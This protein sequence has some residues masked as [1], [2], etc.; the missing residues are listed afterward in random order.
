[1][2]VIFY[3]DGA[4]FNGTQNILSD[5]EVGRL[6]IGDLLNDNESNPVIF[7]GRPIPPTREAAE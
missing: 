6:K 1:M 3:P 2:T 7:P 4:T 5:E